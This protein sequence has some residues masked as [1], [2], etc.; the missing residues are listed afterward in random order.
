MITRISRFPAGAV[1]LA[2]VLAAGG[3]LS[4]QDEVEPPKQPA[5]VDLEGGKKK[6]GSCVVDP[7]DRSLRIP[8]KVNMTKGF[9]EYLMVHDTKG[10]LH[11]SLLATPVMPFEMNVALLLLSYRGAPDWFVPGQKPKPV[12]SLDP[13]Q[14]CTLWIEWEPKPG[15]KK[16]VRAETWIRNTAERRAASEGAFVY[17]GSKIT[18]DNRFAADVDGDHVALYLDARS[19]INNPRPGNDDDENW[20]PSADVAP[21]D[22][23]VTLIVKPFEP[24]SAA[25]KPKSSGAAPEPKPEPPK[26]KS[27]PA[28]PRKPV[29]IP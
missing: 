25:E 13:A 24:A 9:L 3:R 14:Q 5:I 4:A 18:D 1:A 22:T 16:T 6:V 2:L 7:A 20:E 19:V 23:A 21:K 15:Q 8:A 27:S 11:E 17:T 26:D 29:K 10:K 28:T 12:A